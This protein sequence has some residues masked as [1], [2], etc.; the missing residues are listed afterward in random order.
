MSDNMIIKLTDIKIHFSLIISLFLPF[1]CYAEPATII[2]YSIY[3]KGAGANPVTMTITEQFLRIDDVV[4]DYL[5]PDGSALEQ[6]DAANKNSGFILYDRK[7]KVIYSVS[8]DEQQIIKIRSV[9]VAMPSPIELKVHSKKLATDQNAPL[10][11]GIQVENYQL[12][13]N[14]KL[15]SEMV[16]V[17]GLMPDVVAAMG[18]FNQVLA[19]QQAESLRYTPADLHEACDLARHTFYPKSYLEN[20]FPMIVQE[21]DPMSKT[22]IIK[23]SRSLINYKQEDVSDELFVLPRYTILPIN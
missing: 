7:E 11:D 6:A 13:V 15:C 10:I 12:Y 23:H 22:K 21:I 20:G 5:R 16:T 14:D 18:E 4:E 19:G 17:P 9:A 3:E 1:L 8:S 2:K